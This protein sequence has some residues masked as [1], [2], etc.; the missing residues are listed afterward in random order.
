MEREST[1]IAEE[2]G[3]LLSVRGL[4]IQ[5]PDGTSLLRGVDFELRPGE[6]VVLLGGSGAG[7]STFLSA[8]HE[9]DRLEDEG[10]TLTCDAL[11]LQARIGIVPQRGA[12]FDHVS[13]GDNIRLALRNADPPVPAS[14][15]NVREW[16]ASL[17][18]PEGWSESSTQAAHV[19][20]G[21]AQRIAVARTLAGGRRILFMDE[22]SVGLDPYRVRVLA[23][24][25]RR[26]IQE[27]SAAALVITH[28]LDFAAA[29]AD[30]FVYIDRDEQRLVE[31]P[32]GTVPGAAER[33]AADRQ[34]I[35]AALSEE[36]VLRLAAEKVPP[37]APR[38]GT[39][40]RA[41]RERTRDLVAPFA[42][43]PRILASIPLALS[44]KLRDF[45]EVMRVVIKQTLLRPTP[46]FAIVSTLIGYSVLYIFH[47]SFTG[48]DMPLRHDKVFELIG[49]RHII[50]LV[51]PL[52]GILFAATS[53][54]AITAWLG[55]ISLTRQSAALRALGV[56]E[57]RYLWTPAWLGL[58]ASFLCLAALF[59]AGMVLG[60]TVYVHGVE[61]VATTW[62]QAYEIVTAQLLDPT[63][64]ER[65][66]L[67]RAA[68]LLSIYS[69]GIGADAIAKGAKEKETS[70]S[71]TVSMVRNVM[72][73]TLWIVA[74]E[75]VSLPFVLGDS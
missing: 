75:L 74:L 65:K 32:A 62:Q 16:L 60:G 36:L 50:A 31:L 4:T 34:R 41:L 57:H 44:M 23:E 17:H 68:V 37:A 67:V 73:C 21:E 2:P 45:V 72:A 48:G 52:S 42:I 9:R 5:R 56:P 28:D 26:L 24:L 22:P 61:H 20:G 64:E 70:E 46:F 8:L 38:Q 66:L 15:E 13:V 63:Q 69:V 53:A 12:L 47:R 58:T 54:N 39:I 27:R 55:G 1:E 7:K 29:F 3:P 11:D 19:S 10:F 35:E 40:A 25:L 33:D 14:S 51:P 6:I 49:S 18:L 43:I 71:V 30:R 59:T